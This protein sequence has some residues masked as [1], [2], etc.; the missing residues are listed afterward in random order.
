MN[1]RFSVYGNPRRASRPR[2]GGAAGKRLRE[3]AGEFRAAMAAGRYRAARQLAERALA[4]A[5]GNPTVLGDYALCLMREG[6]HEDAYRVYRDIEALAPARQQ[7]LAPTWIDGLAEACGWLGKHDEL[8]RYGYRS[9]AAA[10]ARFSVRRQWA[11]PPGRPT[12]F[13]ARQPER[14][15]IAYS[16]YGAKPRYCE[17]LVMNASIVGELFPAWTCRVYHDDTVPDHVRSRL[18][19][20]GATLIRVDDALRLAMP[21]TMWRFLVLDDPAVARFMIRD[22]DALLSERE[23][24][25]IEAWLD[26]GRWFHHMRDYFTHTELLLAGM[27]AGCRGVFPPIAP[28]MAD[29][30]R[31][32]PDE[33][34][35]TDQYFLRAVLWPTI[36]DSVL[37]H[38]ELF[39]FHDA[40]PFPPHP[41]VRWRDV[42][43][44]VGSNASYRAVGGPSA[45]A[46]GAMQT[47][48][49]DDGTN[50]SLR[51]D[52]IVRD[53]QWSLE[54]PFFLIAAFES[55]DLSVSVPIIA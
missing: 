54:L 35:F 20:A 50:G 14:N 4:L 42:E 9:L 16:L 15:V 34:R 11:V 44:H 43:F 22:A 23:P 12:P 52:A 53:G 5:P 6:R 3:L 55:G 33:R 13:D 17:T 51:Y 26:S 31:S 36:R 30:A 10:D 27:W 46:D 47:V 21:G 24:A 40:R 19:A 18:K 28:L 1:S 32:C 45:L 25:A 7:Q 39:G 2:A 29:F 48:I 37:N 38:D 8:R 49:L 41:P